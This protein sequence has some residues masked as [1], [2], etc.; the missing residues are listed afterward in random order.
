MPTLTL[1][2]ISD[3]HYGH[4]ESDMPR[5]KTLFIDDIKQYIK[6]L[7]GIDIVIFSGDLV[8][9]GQK[10]E[11]DKL[12][13]FFSEIWEK[14]EFDKS[15][16]Y[17]LSVPGNHDIARVGSIDPIVVALKRSYFEDKEISDAILQEGNA[18]SEFIKASFKNYSQWEWSNRLYKPESFVEGIFPGDFSCKIEKKGI[19]LGI[20]GLNSAFMQFYAGNAQKKLDLK[21]KQLLCLTNNDPDEWCRSNSGFNLIVTHHGEEWLHGDSQKNFLSNIY[22]QD[23]F[24]AH[25]YGHMHEPF[26]LESSVGGHAPR[27]YRQCPS[28]FGERELVSGGKRLHGYMIYQYEINNKS[29]DIIERIF[30]RKLE[31]AHGD[32]KFVPD[33]SFNISNDRQEILHRDCFQPQVSDGSLGDVSGILTGNF[34]VGDCAR[35]IEGVVNTLFR[36]KILPEAH[37]LVIRSG[38]LESAAECLVRDKF[39][40]VQAEWGMGKDDFINVLISKTMK[41]ESISKV[42][43]DCEACINIEEVLLAVEKQTNLSLQEIAINMPDGIPSIFI[44]DNISKELIVDFKEGLNDI[45]QILKDI[46]PNIF[47]VFFTRYSASNVNNCIILKELDRQE[48]SLYIENNPKFV[49]L[50]IDEDTCEVIFARTNGVPMLIDYVA[51]QLRYVDISHVDVFEG[52]INTLSEPVPKALLAAYSSLEHAEKKEGSRALTLL[53]ILSLLPQGEQLSKIRRIYHTQPLFPREVEALEKFSLVDITRGP[54]SIIFSGGAWIAM[55]VCSEPTLRVPRQIREYV[56]SRMSER[57]KGDIVTRLAE[58]YFG[59]DWRVG[60][61]KK[62]KENSE[63]SGEL[64]NKYEILRQLIAGEENAA[65]YAARLFVSHCVALYSMDRYRDV[66]TLTKE[67]EST[68][69]AFELNLYSQV[70]LIK[71]K[72]LRMLGRRAESSDILENLLASDTLSNDDTASAYLNLALGHVHDDSSFA[73]DAA[74]KVLKYSKKNDQYYMQAQ[75]TLIGLE[76][77]DD[78][79][80]NLINHRLAC[81]KKG[82][83][84]TSNN[85]SLDLAE[86]EEDCDLKIKYFNDVICSKDDIT[87]QI[88]A[89]AKKIIYIFKKKLQDEYQISTM[90]L[91][92]VRFG[93]SLCFSQRDNYSFNLCHK[94]LWNVFKAEKDLSQLLTLFKYSSIIWRLSGNA[95][96]EREFCEEL[97]DCVASFNGDNAENKR[98]IMGY[99]I[100]RVSALLGR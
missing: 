33:Y 81:D 77:G 63:L 45:R 92:I 51:N 50:N 95:S 35:D 70:L 87:N 41:C 100:S 97:N 29:R 91:D 15:K 20:V 57:R 83:T 61:S 47:F 21:T 88:K 49:D 44:F 72:S 36:S 96:R 82:Y 19:Q 85:I 1:L 7:G 74:R 11:Y 75:A 66:V 40:W 62:M 25:M 84:I 78:R 93:Y 10:D 39:I 13:I 17:F 79:R 4:D 54:T 56:I 5:I 2:H 24:F 65:L 53:N 67:F 38:E 31:D 32:L 59:K 55:R 26:T 94:A 43:V 68:L 14:L 9:S 22:S 23:R 46:N 52:D 30:P 69:K 58:L 86:E 42:I 18:Y 80:G 34:G 99:F 60:K 76:D 48:T 27:R 89:A 64:E 12:S 3:L 73:K 71:A 28:L 37:Q 6:K 98:N 16:T 90:E 8:F